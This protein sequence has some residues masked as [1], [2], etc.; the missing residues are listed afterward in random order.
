MRDALMRSTWWRSMNVFQ[1]AGL[2]KCGTVSLFCRWEM[3][4]QMTFTS[5]RDRSITN[6]RVLHRKRGRKSSYGDEKKYLIYYVCWGS[7]MPS[8]S[9]SFYWFLL[10][11]L[12]LSSFHLPNSRRGRWP[13]FFWKTTERY[14]SSAAL[15]AACCFSLF[16][17]VLWFIKT[18][19]KKNRPWWFLLLLDSVG[20]GGRCVCVDRQTLSARVC[21]RIRNQMP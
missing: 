14:R 12:A 6:E 16:L 21:V 11:L 9:S 3:L 7:I 19:S 1:S 20:I 8:S 15:K 5:C 2:D 10:Y 18:S 13:F 4:W 17:F